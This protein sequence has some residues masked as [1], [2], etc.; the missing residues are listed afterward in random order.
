MNVHRAEPNFPIL[1]KKV[2]RYANTPMN[3]DK[4]LP[5]AIIGRKY[6]I[7]GNLNQAWNLRQRNSLNFGA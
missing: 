2:V 3:N 5:L 6:Y 7:F 1:A 4:L